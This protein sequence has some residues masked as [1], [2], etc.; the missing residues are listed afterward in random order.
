MFYYILSR[1]KNL[2][3]RNDLITGGVNLILL[4]DFSQFPPVKDSILFF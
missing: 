4:G 3:G 2:T 1:L